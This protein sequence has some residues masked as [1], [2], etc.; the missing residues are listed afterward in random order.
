M[1]VIKKEKKK[2]NKTLVTNAQGD[3]S[4]LTKDPS[5]SQNF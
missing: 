4:H 1:I 5:S 3:A 2:Q